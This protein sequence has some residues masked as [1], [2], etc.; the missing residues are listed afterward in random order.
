MNFQTLD[1]MLNAGFELTW[2]TSLQATV[3]VGL[4][5][6]VQVLFKRML[7]PR[8]RYLLGCWCCCVWSCRWFLQVRSASL[9]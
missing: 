8:W 6:L 2:R 5:L 4:V 3:L 7:T 1:Q 9:I